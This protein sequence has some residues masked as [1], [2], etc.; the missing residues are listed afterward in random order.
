MSSSSPHL[1][2]SASRPRLLHRPQMPRRG[3]QPSHGSKPFASRS[4]SWSRSRHESP[5]AD[6]P[7][8]T[9]ANPGKRWRRQRNKLGT[10]YIASFCLVFLWGPSSPIA[11]SVALECYSHSY[12]GIYLK[13]I[14]SG[15]KTLAFSKYFYE[16][17]EIVALVSLMKL[18]LFKEDFLWTSGDL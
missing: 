16:K 18:F 14:Q 8:K 4:Q 10:R 11:S 1:Q 12:H 13:Y 5:C 15:C 3:E 9:T 7:L 17:L 2:R 6:F